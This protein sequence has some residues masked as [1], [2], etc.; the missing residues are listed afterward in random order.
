MNGAGE[1]LAKLKFTVESVRTSEVPV[2]ML[3]LKY[4]AARPLPVPAATDPTLTLAV[5][6][7]PAA[8]ARTV[9]APD[10]EAGALQRPVALTEPTPPAS[11]L[12]VNAGCTASTAPN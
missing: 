1:P 9:A 5:P 7:T 4:T 2:S 10:H 3:L 8:A 12:H 6:L 11:M